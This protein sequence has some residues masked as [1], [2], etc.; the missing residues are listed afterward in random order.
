M[1][2]HLLDW[3]ESRSTHGTQTRHPLASLL[4]ISYLT[5]TAEGGFVVSLHSAALLLF[6]SAVTI[7]V[8]S[9]VVKITSSGRDTRLHIVW[10][11][12]KCWT[13][14]KPEWAAEFGQLRLG[15]GEPGREKLV[16]SDRA[17]QPP[18]PFLLP[19]TA[20]QQRFPNFLLSRLNRRHGVT[21]R[22]RGGMF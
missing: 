10:T 16:C 9:D 7:R 1:A 6:N 2:N 14:R 18:L 21:G 4:L 11:R 13:S 8:I 12:Y 15:P 22:G 3:P 5:R 17:P 19:L 20:G